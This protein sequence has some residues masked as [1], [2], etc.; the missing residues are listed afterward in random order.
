ALSHLSRAEGVESLYSLVHGVKFAPLF[1][2]DLFRNQVVEHCL[3]FWKL[4]TGLF[5]IA[6]EHVNREAGSQR[7]IFVD[8][9]LE[10][11]NAAY[12]PE[13]LL[14][15]CETNDPDKAPDHA[16][17][18]RRVAYE[19][20]GAG[21]LQKNQVLLSAVGHPNIAGAAKMAEQCVKAIAAGTM[22]AAV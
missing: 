20:V 3:R 14:W 11:A 6:V 8:S 22:E 17:A 18:E 5:R 4:S 13:S 7:A 2:P 9:G 21:D 1:H 16:V 12:A 10:D 15:E 19:L